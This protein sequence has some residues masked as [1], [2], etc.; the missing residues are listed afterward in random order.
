MG[1]LLTLNNNGTSNLVHRL[2]ELYHDGE[3]EG[4]VVGVKLKSGEFT[5]GFTDSISFLEKLGLAQA[6]I[7]DVTLVSNED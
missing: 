4:L 7:N 5:C 3:I 1:Q 2:L 6:I